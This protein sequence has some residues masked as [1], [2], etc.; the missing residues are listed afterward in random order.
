MSLYP[1][2]KSKSKSTSKSSSSK[3]SIRKSR[4]NNKNRYR[5]SSIVADESNGND[6]DDDIRMGPP[7]ARSSSSP[8]SM[9]S[10]TDTSNLMTLNSCHSFDQ[11]IDTTNYLYASSN[12]AVTTPQ[13]PRLQLDERRRTRRAQQ[14]EYQQAATTSPPTP[15]FQLSPQRRTENPP[16]PTPSAADTYTTISMSQSFTNE[17]DDSDDTSFEQQQVMTDEGNLYLDTTTTTTASTVSITTPFPYFESTTDINNG[18]SDSRNNPFRRLR[19]RTTTMTDISSIYENN[20]HEY[21]KKDVQDKVDC[22]EN[23][24]PSSTKNHSTNTKKRASHE[25]DGS[26]DGGAYRYLIR[27]SPQNYRH[28]GG[29]E[30]SK[31]NE[32][33]EEY[34]YATPP[35]Q[36]EQQYHQDEDV[37]SMASSS[38]LMPLHPHQRIMFPEF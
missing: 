24:K 37:I 13:T 3:S 31:Y 12:A 8:T 5:R 10:S 18:V 28:R 27:M 25:D 17:F 30:E 7:S 22:D 11:Y 4:N 21:G 19:P 20:D 34:E 38:L 32:V 16:S 23:I 15:S 29:V 6:Y 35:Q 36:Q 33:E 26:I 9:S 1:T 2:K 14:Q